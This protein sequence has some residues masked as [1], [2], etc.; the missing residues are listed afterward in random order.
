VGIH[1]TSQLQKGASW[2]K[3]KLRS[4]QQHMQFN[5]ISTLTDTFTGQEHSTR[6]TI[7][8]SRFKKAKLFAIIISDVEREKQKC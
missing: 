4:V 7:Q 1:P 5:P 2:A 6:N 3:G 8:D